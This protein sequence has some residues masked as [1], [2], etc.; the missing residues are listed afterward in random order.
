MLRR[1]GKASK[2][3][4]DQKQHFFTQNDSL[5][6][7]IRYVNAIYLEQPV[8][9]KCKICRSPLKNS[10]RH[11]ASHEL[12][13][14]FCESCDHLNGLHN[15]SLEFSSRLYEAEN[16]ANY[17]EH[18]SSGDFE[19][20]V[21]SVYMPKYLFLENVCGSLSSESV[22]DL[23]CGGG[24]FVYC[25][26]LNGLNIRGLDIGEKM[27]DAGNRF[28]LDRFGFEPLAHLPS[29]GKNRINQLKT[30]FDSNNIVVALGVIEHFH[31][32]DVVIDLIKDA[33]FNYLYFSVPLYSPSVLIE[34]A[35][36]DVFPR[37]LGAGHTHLFTEQSLYHFLDVIGF[38][39]IGE[40][41]FGSDVLDLIRSLL[42]TCDVDDLTRNEMVTTLGD[43]A[44]DIQLVFDKKHFCSEIHVVTKRKLIG[45]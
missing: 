10:Q 29:S 33:S 36:P 25:G 45:E 32:L 26:L 15:D 5:L 44:D 7:Q 37:Q 16:L 39:S 20:R 1:Y 30:A 38:D 40:W 11:I 4:L 19:E 3:Y 18:Y 43:I 22:L 13:Y 21:D 31:D 34:A 41:R 6:E 42:V 12:R 8:R 2:F 35:F 14:V 28:L 24:H 27:L 23:G 9:E 17:D